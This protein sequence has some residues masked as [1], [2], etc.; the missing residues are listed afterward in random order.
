M[1]GVL[2]YSHAPIVPTGGAPAYVKTTLSRHKQK[3]GSIFGRPLG[4][5]YA[6]GNPSVRL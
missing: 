1:P 6:I 5:A 4:Q 2:A 3:L